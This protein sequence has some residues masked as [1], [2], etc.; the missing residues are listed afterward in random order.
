MVKRKKKLSKR[1]IVCI[2]VAAAALAAAIALIITNAFIPVKYLTAYCVKADKN[3]EGQTRVSFIDV[4]FGDCALIELPDGK[5]VLIDGGDGAYSNNAKILRFLNSRGIKTIDYLVCTSVKDEHCG[6]LAEILKYKRVG[7]AYIPYSLNT[8][9]TPEYRTFINALDKYD[10]QFCHACVGEGIYSD[11][12]GYF[13]TFLSPVNYQS[14]QS[15]YAAMNSDAT[16]ANI[17]NASVVTWLECGQTAFAFTSDARPAALKRILD[18]Y[19]ACRELGQDFC[20]VDGH[21]VELE[22]CKIV[23][24][25]AHAGANN[26]YAPW[27]DFI[28][29][30][31]AVVSVGKSFADYPSLKALSDI[32]NY[33]DPL[34][35]MYDGDITV[36]L[37]GGGYTVVTAKG[38]EE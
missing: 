1:I 30:E 3:A 18:E 35:T 27:Y 19:A 38:G 10:V 9:I 33:C 8:R 34:Y 31:Q 32:C 17:E 13:L 7:Y 20:Q 12:Y 28:Q 23:T 26:T 5:T 36:T 37:S 21:A 25:P 22:K 2:S 6:G 11:E 15:E 4:D 14:P 29:P 24:A 16:T